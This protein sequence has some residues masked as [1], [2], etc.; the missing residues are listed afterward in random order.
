MNAARWRA[1]GGGSLVHN[2]LLRSTHLA[3]RGKKTCSILKA[4]NKVV[5]QRKV[6]SSQCALHTHKIC[7]CE[8]AKRTKIYKELNSKCVKPVKDLFIIQALK[9]RILDWLSFFIYNS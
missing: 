1:G 9:Y 8:G 7:K 2:P 6:D 3:R 5:L 4:V